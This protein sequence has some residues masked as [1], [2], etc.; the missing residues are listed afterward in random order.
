MTSPINLTL[1]HRLL[2]AHLQAATSIATPFSKTSPNSHPDHHPRHFDRLQHTFLH[3]HHRLNHHHHHHVLPTAAAVLC[4]HTHPQPHLP[5]S[6]YRPLPYKI[7]LFTAR[8]SSHQHRP[9]ILALLHRFHHQQAFSLHTSPSTPGL[10]PNCDGLQPKAMASTLRA[11]ASILRA[12]ASILIAMASNLRAMASIL[13]AMA[14][15]P[16]ATASNLKSFRKR[17]YVGVVFTRFC[18]VAFF[19]VF[20]GNGSCFGEC[21]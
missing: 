8:L 13:R 2:L 17:S 7:R 10:H 18:G 14:S 11:M 21:V 4:A 15:I 12:T 1:A 19:C 9:H 6:Q 16:R 3:A 5:V 20:C